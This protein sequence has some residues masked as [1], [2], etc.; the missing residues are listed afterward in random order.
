MM[1]NNQ[2]TRKLLKALIVTVCSSLTI[3]VTAT[4]NDA[5]TKSVCSFI[6]GRSVNVRSGPGNNYKVVANLKRGDG[7]RA[8]YRQGKWVKLTGRVYGTAPNERVR[9]FNGWV[10]NQF[11]NGCSEDQFDRWRR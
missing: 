9:S 6:T 5:A 2:T 10:S 1:T 4:P 11:I 3:A 7:V 8:N